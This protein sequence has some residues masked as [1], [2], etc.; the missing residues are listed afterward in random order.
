MLQYLVIVGALVNFFGVFP[1][2]RNTLNGKSKPNRIT[3]LL[4]SIAPLIGTA[5]ALADGVTWA[6]LPIFM[7]GFG[8]LLVF[9]ASFVNKDSYW[10]LHNFDWLCGAFS[11]LALILW[12]ITKNPTIALVFAIL[13]DLSAGLPTLIKSW[14]FPETETASAYATGIIN[15]LTGF[16]AVK[17]WIFPQYAFILYLV[18]INSLFTFF[19]LRKKIFKTEKK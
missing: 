19:I 10:K 6:V 7:S 8:P 11:V 12:W 16:A 3:W 17:I 2:I 9:L 5:A 1:Y 15:A 18:I 4:W 14:M 13:G